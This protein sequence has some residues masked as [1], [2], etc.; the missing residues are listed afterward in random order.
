[1]DARNLPRRQTPAFVRLARGAAV[2]LATLLALAVW[3]GYG[4]LLRGGHVH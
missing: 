2:V 1:M 4:A 3:T